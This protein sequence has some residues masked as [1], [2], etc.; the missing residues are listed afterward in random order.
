MTYD[1]GLAQRIREELGE[2]TDLTEKRMFGGLSFL[3]GGNMT[4]GVVGDE[5]IAR[6][7]PD[8]AQEALARPEARPMDFTGRPMRGWVTVSGP[9]LAEDL[10]LRDWVTWSLAFA[11]TLPPK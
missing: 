1:E 10:V 9:A 4:V 3:V 8:R 2:R 11:G 5:L 6:V 7:G